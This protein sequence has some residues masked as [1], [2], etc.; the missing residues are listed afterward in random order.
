MHKYN[1]KCLL[2]A[3]VSLIFLISCAENKPHLVRQKKDFAF[4]TV[5][6][7]RVKAELFYKQIAK[8]VNTK[9]EFWITGKLIF[10]DLKG[11]YSKDPVPS[12]SYWAGDQKSK[13][14]FVEQPT[15]I[16]SYWT[17]DEKSMCYIRT[18]IRVRRDGVKKIEAEKLSLEYYRPVLL[19]NVILGPDQ[20]EYIKYF[21]L[22]YDAKPLTINGFNFIEQKGQN[23]NSGIEIRASF[24]P[25][26]TAE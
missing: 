12:Y 5:E 24:L 23:I 25:E 7:E 18:L 8:P 9:D 14:P 26:T 20:A 10:D 11:W 2:M 21:K 4:S 15:P 3:F 6:A 1:G 13:A 22:S 19:N 17:G 16:Y